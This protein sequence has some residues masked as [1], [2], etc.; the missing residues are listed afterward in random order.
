M[1]ETTI[2]RQEVDPDK[3]SKLVEWMEEVDNRESEIIETLQDEGVKTES[4]FLERSP[5]GTFLVTYMEADDLQQV[6]EIFEQSTHDI[7]IEYKQTV[8]ECLTD[9]QPVGS[10]ES[11]YH[12]ADPDR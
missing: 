10:F 8:Q 7:D 9:G 4:A 11:L 6:Q 5:Q 1:A 12:A 3:V 2:L